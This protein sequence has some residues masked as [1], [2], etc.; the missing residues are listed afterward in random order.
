MQLDAIK[1]LRV[2]FVVIGIVLLGP[3]GWLFHS[4]EQR[5]SA[6]RRLRH[7]VVAERIFDELERELTRVLEEEAARPSAAYEME[8]HAAGWPRFVVGYFKAREGESGMIAAAELD[9]DRRKRIAWALARVSGS[10]SDDSRQEPVKARAAQAPQSGK[11]SSF[12]VLQKL[13]R[14]TEYRQQPA[15][16]PAQ[17]IAPA[18]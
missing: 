7:E 8:M 5:L 11:S 1:R 15:A 14:A 10:V 3:L 18:K 13:N 2:A 12:D 9:P 16:N 4:V 17:S 6:Q